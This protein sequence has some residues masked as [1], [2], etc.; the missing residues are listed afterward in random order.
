MASAGDG[1]GRGVPTQS[2]GRSEVLGSKVD[3]DYN[4]DIGRHVKDAAAAVLR[5]LAPESRIW[6]ENLD[7]HRGSKPGPR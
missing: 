4:P 3:R 1:E 7:W 5:V 2:Q 6:L